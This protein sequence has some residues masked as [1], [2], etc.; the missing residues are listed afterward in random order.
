M[1]LFLEIMFMGGVFVWKVIIVNF[2]IIICLL[3]FVF[4]SVSCFDLYL[5]LCEKCCS[6]DML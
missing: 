3:I 1:V 2:W 5:R 6:N 4:V